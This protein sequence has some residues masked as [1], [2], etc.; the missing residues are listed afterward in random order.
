LARNCQRQLLVESGTK[1]ASV[2]FQSTEEDGI[3]WSAYVFD[4]RT[5]LFHFSILAQFTIWGFSP[6]EL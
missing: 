2:F 3:R 4:V 6:H 1:D 5:G